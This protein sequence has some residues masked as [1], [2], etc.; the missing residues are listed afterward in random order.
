MVRA[1]EPAQECDR[2][3]LRALARRMFRHP[4]LL[5]EM[6]LLEA[7]DVTMRAQHAR[8]HGGA[9]AAA[10]DDE[11]NA[12]VGRSGGNRS[13]RD[14]RR[15]RGLLRPAQAGISIASITPPAPRP[16]RAAASRSSPHSHPPP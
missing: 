9:A 8:H 14:A 4:Q 13:G 5:E 3:V 10:A 16:P 12:C 2:L 15:D 11:H 1:Q 7:E 6:Q